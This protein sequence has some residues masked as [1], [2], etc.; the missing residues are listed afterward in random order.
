M[1]G[2][3][4]SFTSQYDDGFNSSRHIDKIL[5][6]NI[7]ADI[8]LAHI[9][10]HL[11]HQKQEKTTEPFY[12]VEIG[13]GHGKFGFYIL[14]RL[15]KTLAIKNLPIDTVKYVCSIQCSILFLDFRFDMFIAK[16]LCKVNQTL[17]E[18]KFSPA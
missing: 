9:S 11:A 3:S 10:D 15:Q 2:T 16:R 13:A 12:I 1:T 17:S 5:F 6:S 14:K 18:C 8:I 4:Y 7:Y